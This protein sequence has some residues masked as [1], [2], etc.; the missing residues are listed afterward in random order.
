MASAELVDASGVFNEILP[1][2]YRLKEIGSLSEQA[3]CLGLLF[4][5]EKRQ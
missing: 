3:S 4:Y 5:F 2:I 1:C